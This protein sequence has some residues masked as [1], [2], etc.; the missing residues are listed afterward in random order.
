M[1][2][3]AQEV[4]QWNL[5]ATAAGAAAGQHVVAQTRTYA[6]V[7]LA[8]HDALNAIDRRYAPY[9]MEGSA[10]AGTL[11][12]IAV[13]AAARDTL[14]ALLPSQEQ[15]IEA[16][17]TQ[18]LSAVP[19]SAAKTRSVEIGKQ[20]AAF[21]LLIRS[22][23]GSTASVPWSPG[24]L[25][26]QYR[27][28]PPANAPAALTHWGEIAPFTYHDKASFR[29]VPPPDLVSAKYARAVQE[30]QLIGRSDSTART[31]MQSEIARYWYE[32][33]AQGWNRIART[34]AE[35]QELDTW[36]TARLFAL[37]NL[38][39][40]DGYI[41]SFESKYYYNFWRPI[42]AI[43][44]G[45]MDGNPETSAEPE[46]NSYLISPPIPDWPSAHATVGAAAAQVL[47]GALGTDSI[48]FSMTSG[49]P[50]AGTQRWFY[51]FSQ[52]AL[53]N[54]NSRALAGIHFR[55]ACVAGLRQGEAVGAWIFANF[56]RPAR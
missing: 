55:E 39:L 42:T 8:I 13:A 48:A 52:A 31:D 32:A 40:A 29:A 3:T 38:A 7:H 22:F 27:P 24:V 47:A 26:G 23:D 33:S 36:E 14:V 18:A 56:L 6:I 15:Q 44:E 11:P 5:V 51:S 30:I 53:E 2:L 9:L 35:S 20:A 1:P 28:T 19:D 37:V 50:Y 34:V 41:A 12:E 21:I 16:A 54:A 4:V 43:R 49:P 25:P 17:Y 46:W 45:Y 10:S